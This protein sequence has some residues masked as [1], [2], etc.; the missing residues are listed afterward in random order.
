M[1]LY[2]KTSTFTLLLFAALLAPIFMTG[3]GGEG[4]A[5]TVAAPAQLS[6]APASTPPPVA[7]TAPTAPPV[8]ARDAPDPCTPQTGSFTLT[9]TGF[10][11]TA[12]SGTAT[13]KLFPCINLGF[14]F[15]PGLAGVSDDTSFTAGPLPS[16]LIPAT[17]VTQ[18]HAVNGFDNDVES[19]PMS[20]IISAGSSTI[21]YLK[22][23]NTSGWIASGSKG[24]GLQV[25]TVFLD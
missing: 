7:S 14:I 18:E 21:Q 4:S 10:S 12:P 23:G 3:C 24:V 25:I 13:Y 15:L 11:G 16:N 17:I 22:N 6:A 5:A 20:V 1:K 8:T 19:T 2:L 9:A